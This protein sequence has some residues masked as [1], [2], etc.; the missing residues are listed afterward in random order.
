MCES[1]GRRLRGRPLTFGQVLK[2]HRA[3]YNFYHPK[4]KGLEEKQRC[5]MGSAFKFPSLNASKTSIT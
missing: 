5:S 1:R 4:Q 2:I 3:L